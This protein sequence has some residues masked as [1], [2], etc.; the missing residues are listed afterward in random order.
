MLSW[1]APEGGAGDPGEVFDE[2]VF[3][4]LF[5]GCPDCDEVQGVVLGAVGEVA[6]FYHVFEVG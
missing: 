6:G 3:G 5:A 2:A 1:G 4:E